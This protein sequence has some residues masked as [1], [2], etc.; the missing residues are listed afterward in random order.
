M[1]CVIPFKIEYEF[2]SHNILKFDNTQGQKTK[3]KYILFVKILNHIQLNF[4]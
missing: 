2:L 3:F 1:D 4:F